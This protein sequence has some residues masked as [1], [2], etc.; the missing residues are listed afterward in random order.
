M[1]AVQ[2]LVYRSV[3][4]PRTT[5]LATNL[6]RWLTRKGAVVGS[7]VDGRV[8]AGDGGRTSSWA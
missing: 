5:A 2:R 4:Y 8:H 6:F 3:I 7:F 1:L